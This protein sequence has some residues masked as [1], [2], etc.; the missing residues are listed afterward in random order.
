MLVPSTAF[1]SKKI[2]W[3]KCQC[4]IQPDLAGTYHILPV[5]VNPGKSKDKKF[6]A[7]YPEIVKRKPIPAL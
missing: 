6:F 5:A 2:L 4:G 1:E 3:P 7:G